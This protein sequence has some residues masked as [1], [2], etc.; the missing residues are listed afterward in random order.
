LRWMGGIF[1]SW[2]RQRRGSRG[3]NSLAG[4]RDPC[5]RAHRP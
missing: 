5:R 4:R 3:R 2:A 1:P